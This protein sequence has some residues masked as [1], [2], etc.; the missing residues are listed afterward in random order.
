MTR[1]SKT[2]RQAGRRAGGNPSTAVFTAVLFY[3]HALFSLACNLTQRTAVV[4][5]PWLIRVEP[6][7]TESQKIEKGKYGRWQLES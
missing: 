2:G 6:D 4:A 1:R 5:L 3:S 7:R